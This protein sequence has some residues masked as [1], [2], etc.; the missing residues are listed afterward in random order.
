MVRL[1]TAIPPVG[2]NIDFDG[3]ASI[4]SSGPVAAWQE[5]ETPLARTTL[6][7]V[8]PS[9]FHRQTQLTSPFFAIGGGYE[10]TVTLTNTA[11]TAVTVELFARDE[12]GRPIGETARLTLQAG[13]TKAAD[14]ATILRVAT[15]AIYPGPIIRG[16]LRVRQPEK[17]LMQLLASLTIQVFDAQHAPQSLMQYWI[18]EE[19]GQF[20]EIPFV[21]R[22]ESYY[23]AYAIANTVATP[24]T[25]TQV[26][27]TVHSV[28]GRII[29]LINHSLEPQ[30][31]TAQLVTAAE[32][33]SYIRILSDEPVVV[34]GA[35]GTKDGMSAEAIQSQR[36][37]K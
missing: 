34:L 12:G 22:N 25:T 11:L 14:V 4:R 3:Y 32:P 21:T 18:R 13:E 35:F 1:A 8:D 5:I 10:S 30:G 33:G 27:V 26:L 24:G 28:D 6:A 7:A 15:I 16:T 31:F 23:T 19:P 36:L 17:Q 2:F 9:T 20:W 29:N 37:P